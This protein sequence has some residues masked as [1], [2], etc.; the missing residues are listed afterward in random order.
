MTLHYVH[1]LKSS[2]KAHWPFEILHQNP[3]NLA[4]A[5]ENSLEVIKLSSDSFLF[6]SRCNDNSLRFFKFLIQTHPLK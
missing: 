2:E 5:T 1:R 3:I 4:S 6:S